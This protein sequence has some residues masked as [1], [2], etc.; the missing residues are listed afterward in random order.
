MRTLI[1]LLLTVAAGCGGKKTKP[2]EEDHSPVKPA[3]VQVPT[4]PDAAPAVAPKADLPAPKMLHLT[5]KSTPEGA[6]ASVD[7]KPLGKTPASFD[8][9]DNGKEHDFDIEKDGYAPQKFK[10][11]P[12]RDGLVAWVQLKSTVVVDAGD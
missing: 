1:V 11:T 7:G 4:P 2:K 8:L 5:L 6:D 3:T 10:S 9:E 12:M